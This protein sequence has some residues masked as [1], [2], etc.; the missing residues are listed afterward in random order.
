MLKCINHLTLLLG[1]FLLI[2]SLLLV[3]ASGFSPSSL[4]YNLQV[5]EQKCQIITITSDSDTIAVSDK[6]AENKDIE[7]KTSLF[8]ESADYHS[9]SIDY[10]SQISQPENKVEV[11]LS[12]NKV[13]E[14]HGVMLLREEQEGNS[15]VQMGIWLKV[16]IT[17]TSEPQA[18]TTN[19]NSGSSGGGSSGGSGGA[20][21]VQNKTP[22]IT[23]QENIVNEETETSEE[24]NQEQTSGITGAV[25]G[26]GKSASIIIAVAAV[27]VIAGILV[28]YKNYR[29]KNLRAEGKI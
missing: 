13:G 10:P 5:N 11:C 6:W 2:N 15:I 29:N 23:A 14:Y 7:W 25:I 19:D 27:L 28:Y 18:T 26:G 17:E 1:G 9:I 12:G 21:V 22:E 16:T 20:I 3:S 8:D 4:V 24:E